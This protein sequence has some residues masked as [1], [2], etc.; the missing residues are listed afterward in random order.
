MKTSRSNRKRNRTIRGLVAVALAL[1]VGVG[2]CDNLLEVQAP[3]VIASSAWDD[4]ANAELLIVSAL[5]EFEC[6]LPVYIRSTGTIAHELMVSGIIGVWQNWG[7]RWDILRNDSGACGNGIGFYNPLQTARYKADQGYQRIEG[8]ADAQVRERTSKLATL[9]AYG[10][11]TYTLMG[12]AMCESAI[13][14]GPLVTREQLFEMAEERF[15][16][17]ID[18]AQ[19]AGN[20]AILNMARVGR[21]R[22]RLNLGKRAEAAADALLV[23]EGFVRN[24]TFSDVAVRRRNSMSVTTHEQRNWSVHF[25]YHNLEVNGVPDT[26]VQLFDHKRL[27]VDAQT[28]QWSPMKHS[29]RSS[30]IPIARWEEAQL[31]IAEVEGGQTAVNIIN[32]LRAKQSLPLFVSSDPA[33][34]A[35][36]VV[37][38]RRRELFLEG[39]RL[40]DMLR[41][42]IPFPTGVTHKGQPYGDATCVPLPD[43]ERFNNPNI[44]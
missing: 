38:E 24:A 17:A 34:I 30:P 13:D 12:E 25:A 14:G 27:G 8:F 20:A 2:G 21:A 36:Q 4:P 11:Y 40:N 43:A 37:E 26:R 10:G 39:H 9:A 19:A 18:H 6:M 15:T 41:L 23:P 32:G 28:P 35:A 3:G 1:G 42:G 7:A 29:S 33:E 22:I 16:A 31:I 5:G 44:K